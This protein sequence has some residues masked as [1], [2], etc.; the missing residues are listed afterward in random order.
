MEKFQTDGVLTD[1]NIKMP[2][3]LLHVK[4]GSHDVTP[5]VVLTPTQVQ[6]QPVVNWE[7][8]PN[9]FYSIVMNDPDAPSRDNPKSREWQHWCVVNVPG[10][11]VEAGE[12]LTEYVGA[13][14]PKGSGLH[15]YV[16]LVFK[17]PTGRTQFNENYL[18]SRSGDGRGNHHVSEFASTYSLGDPV[19]GNYF[20][21]GPDDY[22]P[23]SDDYVPSSDDHVPSSAVRTAEWKVK[24]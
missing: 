1:M 6:K 24:F 11:N 15:R 8:D 22:V 17:Q 19:S 21:A 7:A 16:L 20:K 12:V 9:A 18:T 14:P 3:S 10:S 4:Y 13:G 2:A 5:G 23:S